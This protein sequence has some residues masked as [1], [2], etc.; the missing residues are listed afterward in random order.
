MLCTSV[1]WGYLQHSF[2][3]KG[4]FLSPGVA[5]LWHGCCQGHGKPLCEAHGR[6]GKGQILALASALSGAETIPL[7]FIH[8][9]QW[10][11]RKYSREELQRY[12]DHSNSVPWWLENFTGKQ[13]TGPGPFWMW[14]IWNLGLLILGQVITKDIYTHA[15][16]LIWCAAGVC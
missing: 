11:Q 16:R 6:S 9:I 13:E 5:N 4:K 1:G 10:M 2:I 8:F 3:Q 15:E 14:E 12:L 7:L